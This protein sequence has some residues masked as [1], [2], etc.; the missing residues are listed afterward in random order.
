MSCRVTFSFADSSPAAKPLHVLRPEELPQFL[1]GPGSSWAS[2]LTATG[3]EAGLG[4][5][6]LLPAPDGGIAGAVAGYGTAQARRRLRFGLAKAVA[7][8]PK[9]PGA[10]VAVLPA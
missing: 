6:R 2:W 3:F 7:G 1:S 9:P 10:L 5:V 4:D 8:L